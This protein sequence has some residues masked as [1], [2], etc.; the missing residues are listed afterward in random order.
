MLKMSELKR[1][2]AGVLKNLVEQNDDSVYCKEKCSVI[3]PARWMGTR[4]ANTDDG[5]YVLAYF[6][7]KMKDEYMLLAASGIIQ[8]GAA[9]AQSIIIDGTECIEFMYDVGDVVI[10]N[11]NVAVDNTIPYSITNIITKKGCIIPYATE[12]DFLKLLD[13]IPVFCNLSL[14]AYCYT[15]IYMSYICRD[16]K[17]LS[18]PSRLSN[19][20]DYRNVGLNDIQYSVQN[21]LSRFSGG[22]L[23][24][25][26]QSSLIYPA[27]HASENEKIMRS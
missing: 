9:N 21:T 24:T 22:Y 15:N 14:P 3:I 10:V 11:L 16:P 18:K 13:S 27:E 23:D 1:N 8:I 5:N 2:P 7:I 25:G 20:K 19:S 12:D 17:D 26:I 4:L 6:M